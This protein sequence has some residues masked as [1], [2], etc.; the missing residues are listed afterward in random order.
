[1]TPLRNGRN[2]LRHARKLTGL[3][4]MIVARRTDQITPIRQ[5]IDR[6]AQRRWLS[7]ALRTVRRFE[8]QNLQ[9]FAA[10]I[11]FQT[12]ISLIPLL[13]AITAAAS[14]VIEPQVLTSQILD[15]AHFVAPRSQDLLG[16]MIQSVT[17]LRGQIGAASIVGLLW[18]GTTLFSALRRGLNAATGVQR[19]RRFI[20]GRVVDLGVGSLTG[21]MLMLSIV[22][23]AGATIV[24]PISVLGSD[25]PFAPLGALIRTTVAAIP[26]ITTTAIFTAL[27]RMV[28]AE[29]LPWRAA[30]ISGALAA[31]LFEAGKTLFV[32]YVATFATFNAIYGP[33]ATVVVL[34]VWIYYSSLIVL[35]SAAF[36]SELAASAHIR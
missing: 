6:L 27:F 36:G 1:M 3:L 20:H 23:T 5:S 10:A 12:I 34:L 4:H 9:T 7:A 30:V 15:L 21:L 26:L 29:P 16:N 35:A 25:N 24:D 22:F 32:W 2:L 14:F 11:S 33:L 13:A 18:T 19:R 28:P 31:V 8:T 17:Q